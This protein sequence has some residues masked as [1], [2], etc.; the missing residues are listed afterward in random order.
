M[1]SIY[2]CF[3]I[4]HGHK[5]QSIPGRMTDCSD[6]CIQY[7]IPVRARQEDVQC[8]RCGRWQHKKCNSG[9]SY[10]DYWT[11]VK[12]STSIDWSCNSCTFADKPTSPP[13]E[14]KSS[15]TQPS[16]QWNKTHVPLQLNKSLQ[17]M[18]HQTFQW[19]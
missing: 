9:V 15:T 1:W 13:V 12:S 6:E 7:L 18:T 3:V 10:A 5:I 8:D 4:G 16:L 19:N 17:L 14:Q 11:P 2:L